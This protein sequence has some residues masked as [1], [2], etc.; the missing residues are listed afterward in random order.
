MRL[1]GLVWVYMFKQS[2]VRSDRR[3]LSRQSREF[4]KVGDTDFDPKPRDACCNVKP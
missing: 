4:P 2:L 3:G 1:G